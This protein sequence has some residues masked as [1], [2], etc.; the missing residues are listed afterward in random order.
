[1]AQT[2]TS[3][4]LVITLGLFCN[5]NLSEYKFKTLSTTYSWFQNNVDIPPHDSEILLPIDWTTNARI[6]YFQL[7]LS[8]PASV[9]VLVKIVRLQHHMC[10]LK[11]KPD[12]KHEQHTT[13]KPSQWASYQIHT[14]VGC[15][16]AG[17]SG[18]VF[19]ATDCN[20][21]HQLAIPTGITPRASSTC[22]D[23]C[24]DR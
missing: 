17:N 18:N 12:I 16:C 9:V 14:I 3:F 24:R 5:A 23:A 21:N 2:L 11:H 10:R 4:T 22:L 13:H 6:V 1:M 19:P 20:G 15:A 7:V 8:T